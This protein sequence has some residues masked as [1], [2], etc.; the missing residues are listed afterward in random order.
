MAIH[1][2]KDMVVRTRTNSKAVTSL[3]MEASVSRFKVFII[4]LF[5]SKHSVF[6]EILI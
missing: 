2:S 5:E 4:F 6:L 1:S 3:G